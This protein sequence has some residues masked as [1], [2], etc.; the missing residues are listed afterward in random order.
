MPQITTSLILQLA[1]MVACT[2]PL[3]PYP[4]WYFAVDESSPSAVVKT[5]RVMWRY[6][7]KKKLQKPIIMTWYDGLKVYVYLGNDMSRTLFVGGC[8]E[9]NEFFFLNK[10]LRQGMV[11]IDV[12]ASEGL[13]SLFAAK[14]IEPTGTVLACEPSHREFTRLQAN[15]QLNHLRN[16]RA[17]QIGLSNRSGEAMLRVAG[18][19]HEGQNTLGDFVHTNIECSHMEQVAL[20]RLDDLI[21]EERLRQVDIIK[22]DVEGAEFSV[23]DGAQRTLAKFSPLLLLELLDAALR[24]QGS[25]VEEVLALLKSLGY[26]IYTFDKVSGEP[27]KTRQ[28][29]KLSDNIVAA[30][31]GRIWRGL[32]DGK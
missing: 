6:C 21:D 22:L 1:R 15:L 27:V 24:Y 31:P 19:A 30:H 26:E 16:V 8:T 25:S 7:N 20:K 23:I 10:V 9:P 18:Y 3:K 5:R 14:R 13:Y 29:H 4:G 32:N 11:F 17:L 28:H 12:G 2:Q